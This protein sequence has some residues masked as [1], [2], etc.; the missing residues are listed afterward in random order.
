MTASPGI[1]SEGTDSQRSPQ[2]PSAHNHTYV[3]LIERRPGGR[4]IVSALELANRERLAE[5][6]RAYYKANRERLAERRRER[7]RELPPG[8]PRHGTLNGYTN[9]RCRCESCRGANTAYARRR[10]G[11]AA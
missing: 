1:M 5:R 11:G 10:R 9:W 2:E 3:K 8:D 4:L 7:Q 6:Q